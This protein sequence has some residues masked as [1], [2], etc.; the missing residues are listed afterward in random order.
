MKAEL[1]RQKYLSKMAE[2]RRLHYL[3]TQSEYSTPSRESEEM[4]GM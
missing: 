2:E 4:S 3:T 1:A